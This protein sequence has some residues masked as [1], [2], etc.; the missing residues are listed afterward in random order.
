MQPRAAQKSGSG[1]LGFFNCNNCAIAGPQ[2]QPGNFLVEFMD[3][4]SGALAFGNIMY[5][6]WRE[7]IACFLS[8]S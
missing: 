4:N 3:V 1:D 8:K 5:R 6:D 7:V 2:E